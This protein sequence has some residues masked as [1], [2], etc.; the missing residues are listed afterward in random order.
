MRLAVSVAVPVPMR[1]LQI[2]P[3]RAIDVSGNDVHITESSRDSVSNPCASR[4]SALQCG[5]Q[6]GSEIGMLLATDRDSATGTVELRECLRKID[7]TSMGNIDGTGG[8]W[9]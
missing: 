5:N 4:R 9:G 1:V 6:R 8:R 3:E 7:V 2:A